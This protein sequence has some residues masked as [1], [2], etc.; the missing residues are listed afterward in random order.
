MEH[1]AG[2]KRENE[3]KSGRHSRDRP[4]EANYSLAAPSQGSSSLI[5]AR[6]HFFASGD[7]RELV[8][9]TKTQPDE[10]IVF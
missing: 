10:S 5:A 8:D 7:V 2:D 9:G 6:R 4:N 1:T 3:R